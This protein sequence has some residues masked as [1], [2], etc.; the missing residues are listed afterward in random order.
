MK[1]KKKKIK[2]GGNERCS[3]PS[4][5]SQWRWRQWLAEDIAGCPS[6]FS[7]F[8]F[9]LS[10]VISSPSL[11]F[12]LILLLFSSGSD[13]VV[14]DGLRG[15]L[16]VVCGGGGAAVSNRESDYVSSLYPCF[17]FP[18]FLFFL[19]SVLSFLFCFTFPFH[20]SFLPLFFFSFFYR[21]LCLSLLLSPKI[22][23][24]LIRSLLCFSTLKIIVL[25]CFL[26]PFLFFS[27]PSYL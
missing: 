27:L 1:Q 7:I 2:W 10:S 20:S 16:T 22:S 18:F 14:D 26:P 21:P 5:G 4:G 6:F 8:S 15:G 17:S 24:P 13:V 11:C 3:W 25:F 12:S 9:S 19:P 23:L